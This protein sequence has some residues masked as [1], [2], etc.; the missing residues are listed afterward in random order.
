M[1]DLY[2]IL[3]VKRS[4]SEDEIKKAYHGLAM[5]YHPDFNPG[6]KNAEEVF[7]K[8]SSAYAVLSDSIQRSEYDAGIS[9]AETAGAPGEAYWKN[10]YENYSAEDFVRIFRYF[11]SNP[12][13]RMRG[14]AKDLSGYMTIAKGIAVFIAAIIVS[15][16]S[17]RL[18][19]MGIVISFA[20]VFVGIRLIIKGIFEI[21]QRDKNEK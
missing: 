10:P 18:G 13:D 20:V 1:E 7:K 4:A 9:R 15:R 14:K 16:I 17:V 2:E 19:F 5:K 3:G 8:I 6:D 12:P 21:A 11:F